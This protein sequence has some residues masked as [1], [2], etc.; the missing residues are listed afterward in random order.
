MSPP[1]TQQLQMATKG[2]HK[3]TTRIAEVVPLNLSAIGYHDALGKGMGGV[4]F[5][6]P[7]LSPR[8]SPNQKPRL[9]PKVWR[10]EWPQHIKDTLVTEDNPIGTLTNSDLELTGGLLHLEAIVNNFDVRDQTI[11]SKTA[12]LA[13]LY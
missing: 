9:Q 2:Y 4:W 10:C 11:L 5:R 8:Y 1:G 13:T 3:K 7:T 12:N 6:G